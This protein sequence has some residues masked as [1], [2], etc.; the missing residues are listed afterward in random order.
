MTPR[1]SRA[2][3][4]AHHRAA[5]ILSVLRRAR[6]FFVPERE[7][8]PE[9]RAEFEREAEAM[10]VQR[11]RTWLLPVVALSLATASAYATM[12]GADAA[13]RLWQRDQARIYLGAVVFD[14]LLAAGVFSGARWARSH[15]GWM[16][17]AVLLVP[18]ALVGVNTQRIHGGL[19]PYI[20]GLAVAPFAVRASSRSFY[21][22]VAAVTCGLAAALGWAQ[23][24]PSLRS[25]NQISVV[26]LTLVSVGL[27]RL[28]TATL[29][30]ELRS[31]LALRALNEEL[32]ARVEAQTV[33]IR[34]FAT[35]LDEGLEAERR[36]LARELHDDLGQEL[37]A[38]RFEVEAMRA[39]AEDGAHAEE[40]G[41]MS[42]AITRSHQAVRLI[43]ESLRPRILDEE[44]LTAAVHWLARQ[45]RGRTGRPCAVSV[46][47]PAE[48]DAD[49]ALVVFR[50]VQEA[51][52]NVARHAEA[53]RVSV[54]LRAE[55]EALALTIED[56]G[57][58]LPAERVEARHGLVGMRE[59]VEGLGGALEVAAVEPRGTRVTA[60]IPTRARAT[61][62]DPP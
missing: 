40:L 10:N 1:L 32:E 39:T 7:L 25:I 24:D 12:R 61:E 6:D 8:D 43:L 41:R 48:P 4:G 27:S 2:A 59:R 20:L 44:G 54:S 35:R 60:T 22:T 30:S 17:R 46:S 13:T 28:H 26:T 52:T 55:G 3:A 11:L 18:F 38:M 9:A 33:E 36:R 53:T 15:L 29:V 62:G 58:G 31:R 51:L 34:G 21:A 42:S 19:G 23:P 49:A 37:T 56:D 57:R 16:S 45:Y 5:V 50:V 14:L 47:L